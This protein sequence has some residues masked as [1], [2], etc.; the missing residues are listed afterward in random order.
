MDFV[1]VTGKLGQ[2]KTLVS[3]SR[4]KHYIEQGRPVATNCDLFLHH[5]FNR[6]TDKPRVMRVPD[7][8]TLCDLEAI[9]RAYP[10]AKGYDENMNGLLVLDECGDWFNSRNWQD[11]TRSGVNTWFRHARKL[12]WDVYLIVQDI[13]LI[14]S[15]ARESLAASIAR[16]K[17]MD[18]IAIP[19]V[20]MISKALTGYPL[21][22]NKFHVAKVTD[23]D[24]VLLDR[25]IYR[26]SELYAAYDTQQIFNADYDHCTY[27][28]LTPWHI[29]GR[30]K[31]QMTWYNRMRITKIYWKR[32]NKIIV[33][34]VSAAIAA[35]VVAAFAKSSIAE[36]DTKIKALE[37]KINPVEV[38]A[39]DN[40]DTQTFTQKFDGWIY[41][42]ATQINEKIIYYFK[43]K[44]NIR[45]TSNSHA[46]KKYTIVEHGFCLIELID[47]SND[48]AVMLQCT[49]K[50]RIASTRRDLD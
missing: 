47:S 34:A 49:S 28:M 25:W 8:P 1:F 29:F 2:G 10:K 44:N 39:E 42:G 36:Q 12:G 37:S 43:D 13:S 11:K 40:E 18:K 21:R 20:T 35:L 7:K 31:I 33:A 9:G 22:M 26:G 4:I 32:F 48:S 38:N 16:C 45:Y 19:F 41:D 23:A 17:R 46:L 15:Q 24:D 5:M 14:D 27:S 6:E 50:Q 30:Y 3:V